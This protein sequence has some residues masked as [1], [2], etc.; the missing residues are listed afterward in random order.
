MGLGLFNWYL[1]SNT[2]VVHHV[3]EWKSMTL[4][5]NLQCLNISL[6]SDEFL[7][8]TI[9]IKS[10]HIV[11]CNNWSQKANCGE[12]ECLSQYKNYI[13]LLQKTGNL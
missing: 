10:P 9:P 8:T 5:Q 12:K 2:G 11:W 7:Y 13:L 4:M 1:Q 6:P 3:Y